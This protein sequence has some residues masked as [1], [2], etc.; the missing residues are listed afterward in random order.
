V[1]ASI[2]L[3][4]GVPS[5]HEDSKKVREFAIAVRGAACSQILETVLVLDSRL[6]NRE[7]LCKVLRG[8]FNMAAF[9]SVDEC[10]LA[11]DCYPSVM[12]LIFN[13]GG[14]KVTEVKA[15]EIAQ[16]V[17]E[18]APVPV[19]MMAEAEDLA[20]IVKA[21]KLGVRGYIPTSVSIDVCLAAI[22]LAIVG[23]IFVPAN[24]VMGPAVENGEDIVRPMAGMFTSRQ[25][26]VIM[27]LRRGKANKIIAHELNLRES[28]VKVHIRNIMRKLRVRNRTEVAYKIGDLFPSEFGT[29]E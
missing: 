28:T 18:F 15:S 7:C 3:N 21:L 27:A 9:S 22:K 19:V 10:L 16:I 11:K 14:R 12:A 4:G 24:S 2:H 5:A 8:Q 13:I 17:E 1:N 29:Q 26:E 25:A 6:F 20:Q 23:G